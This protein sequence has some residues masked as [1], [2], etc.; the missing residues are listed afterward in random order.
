VQVEEVEDKYWELEAKIPKARISIIEEAEE[1]DYLLSPPEETL[2]T[3]TS[4]RL[5][6]GVDAVERIPLP[7]PPL[8][9]SKP[10]RWA[11]LSG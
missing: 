4:D 5:S 11:S 3:P 7:P 9:D 2:F 6:R 8:K 10:I 1:S